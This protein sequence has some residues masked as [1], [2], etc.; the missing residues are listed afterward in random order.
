VA[1]HDEAVMETSLPERAVPGLP[2]KRIVRDDV[3]ME[4]PETRY[5]RNGE[6]SR[7]P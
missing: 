5:A 3:G 4:R 1:D 6:A 7:V 2:S